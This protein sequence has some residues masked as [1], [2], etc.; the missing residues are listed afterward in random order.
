MKKEELKAILR[1]IKGFE[2]KETLIF[3]RPVL[4]V[5]V[6]PKINSFMFDIEGHTATMPDSTEKLEFHFSKWLKKGE[7]K[8]IRSKTALYLER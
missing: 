6:M 3:F 8:G 7:E 4:Y 5:A 2:K 1:D